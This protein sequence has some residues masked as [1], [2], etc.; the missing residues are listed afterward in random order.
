MKP[1][2]YGIG[3]V[4]EEIDFFIATDQKTGRRSLIGGTYV[5]TAALGCPVE[6]SATAGAR[7]N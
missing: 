3:A 2:F 5:G 7:S 6:R 4:L 1:T